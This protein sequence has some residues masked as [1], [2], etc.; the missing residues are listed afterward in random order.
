MLYLCWLPCCL[1]AKL[2]KWIRFGM[3]WIKHKPVRRQ[4]TQVGGE[5]KRKERKEFTLNN[6]T[7]TSLRMVK[8]MT[9]TSQKE[10]RLKS[11]ILLDRSPSLNPA[12]LHCWKDEALSDTPSRCSWNACT[13]FTIMCLRPSPFSFLL[14]FLLIPRL[15]HWSW[16]GRGQRLRRAET[17][18]RWRHVIGRR[19]TLSWPSFISADKEPLATSS[20]CSVTDRSWLLRGDRQS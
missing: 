8:M 17:V 9:M 16:L 6:L 13:A 5:K 3:C 4:L 18:I 10:A 19:L 12:W 11:S 7:N 20:N 1:M 15:D 14:C 2:A